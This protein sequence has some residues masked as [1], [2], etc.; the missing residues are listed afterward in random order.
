MKVLDLFSGAGGMAEGFIQAGFDVPYAT[1]LQKD[2]ALTYTNRHLQ[3]NRAVKFHCGDIVDLANQKS[4]EEFLKEDINR[5]DVICGGP[6]CQG[7]SLAGK[8]NKNDPRN[9]LVKSYLRI[10]NIVKPKMFVMENV[11]GIMSS[12]FDEFIGVMDDKYVKQKVIDVLEI[13]FEKIGYDV[14]YKILDASDYGVP[15]NRRRVIF[16]GKRKDFEPNK[17]VSFPQKQKN[18]VSVEEAIS[19]LVNIGNGEVVTDYNIKVQ[20]NYQKESRIGRTKTCDGNNLRVDILC[21]HETSKHTKLVKE[22][23]TLLKQG[24]QIQ[25]LLERLKEEQYETY[26]TKKR[27]CVKMLSSKQ[28]PTIMTL[29]DDIV[30]YSEDRI[31]TVREMARLQSFDDSFVFYGKRTTGGEKRKEELPQYTQV[32]NAVPPLLAFAIA[33]EIIKILEG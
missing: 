29:P 22:R 10:L 18:K 12:I 1:D 21:N 8:R 3:L 9:R 24:E 31:L 16:I 17:K 32:G 28:S 30:H 26:K 15:Q 20:S 33:K 19:D 27:N 4:I 5:I 11:L 2:A 7:F 23:F 14:E 13:E 6:P 25:Q